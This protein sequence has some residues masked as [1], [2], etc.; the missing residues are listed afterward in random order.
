MLMRDIWRFVALLIGF[1]ALDFLGRHLGL[2]KMDSA[3]HTGNLVMACM[4]TVLWAIQ[5]KG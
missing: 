4:F 3:D 2:A 5:E 1:S